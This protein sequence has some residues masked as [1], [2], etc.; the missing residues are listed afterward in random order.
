[1]LSWLFDIQPTAHLQLV[2]AKILFALQ[3][4]VICQMTSDN[5]VCYGFDPSY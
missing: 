5:A 3:G 4:P 2:L 1:M